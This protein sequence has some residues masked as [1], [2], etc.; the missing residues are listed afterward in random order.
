ML[1]LLCFC[2]GD[3]GAAQKIGI[4][5]RAF[6]EGGVAA[7]SKT[8]VLRPRAGWDLDGNWRGCL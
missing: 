7:C 3:L 4:G 8:R 6:L 5:D 1:E 2:L